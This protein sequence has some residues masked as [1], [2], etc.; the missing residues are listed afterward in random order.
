MVQTRTAAVLL[1]VNSMAP[2]RRL[3]VASMRLEMCLR[4]ATELGA[5]RNYAGRICIFAVRVVLG[6]GPCRHD[7][8]PILV[9]TRDRSGV[10]HLDIGE[11]LIGD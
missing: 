1:L 11:A 10:A 4:Q 9:A 7:A 5:S 8:Q 6:F 3:R 2:R